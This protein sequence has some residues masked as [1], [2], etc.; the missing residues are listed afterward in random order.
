MTQSLSIDEEYALAR[1]LAKSFGDLITLLKS[2]A[3]KQGISREMIADHLEWSPED[4][5]EVEGLGGDPTISMVQDYARATG[6]EVA[7]T[8][9]QYA[10]TERQYISQPV[11]GKLRSV[12]APA[13]A[14]KH[15]SA[16]DD[17]ILRVDVDV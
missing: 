3:R 11:V 13:R 16:W 15:G 12:T 17:H 2:R 4:V 8:V 9:R 6:A 1:K 14:S 10:F 5:A 7:F